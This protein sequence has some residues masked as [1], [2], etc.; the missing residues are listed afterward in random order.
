M[1][2]RIDVTRMFG[3]DAFNESTMRQ[4]LPKEVFKKLKATMNAGREL[5]LK[6]QA[7]FMSA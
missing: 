5:A 3:A 6:L 1:S 7:F 4:R 2:E